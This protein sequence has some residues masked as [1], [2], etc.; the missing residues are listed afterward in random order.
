MKITR[1]TTDHLRVP[2][3]KPTR[4]SLSDPK[5][6]ALDAVDVVLVLLETD[7]GARGLGFTYTL[8]AGTRAVRALIGTELSQVVVNEDPRDT[9]RLFARAEARFR[10]TGFGGL[11]ARAYCALD[12]ALWDAKARAAGVPLAKLLG[13]SKPAAAFVI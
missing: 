13:A 5:P 3:G 4:V 2:L 12:V 8:G 11:A 6:A 7:T 10:A 1:L 9:D